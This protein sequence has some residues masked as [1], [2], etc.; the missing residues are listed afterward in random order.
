ML[1]GHHST[2]CKARA[3][4][5]LTPQRLLSSSSCRYYF[6]M[7]HVLLTAL[8]IAR[9]MSHLHRNRILHA[10]LKVCHEG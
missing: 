3:P 6:D 1:L 5:P 8:D 2:L 10:D 4:P 9:G 7:S